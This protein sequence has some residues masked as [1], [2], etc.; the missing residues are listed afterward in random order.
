MT[1]SKSLS[2]NDYEAFRNKFGWTAEEFAAK[3][4]KPMNEVQAH[5][6]MAASGMIIATPNLDF[7]SYEKQFG[8]TSTD[9]TSITKPQTA[10]APTSVKLKRG[11]KGDSVV[12][13]FSAIPTTPTDVNKFAANQGVSLHVLR[14][15]KRFD[16]NPSLGKV[17]VAKDKNTKVLMISRI[18]S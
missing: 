3:S 18:K 1:I 17:R 5:I 16:P 9:V 7:K 4:G 2:A 13:A 8:K 12:K 10:T 11:R 6:S 14:Q 15:S